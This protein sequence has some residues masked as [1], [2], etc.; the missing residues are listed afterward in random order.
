ML[1]AC[2]P[3]CARRSEFILYLRRPLLDIKNGS[4]GEHFFAVE[5]LGMGFCNVMFVYIHA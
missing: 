5:I 3:R 1:H 2:T 4:E